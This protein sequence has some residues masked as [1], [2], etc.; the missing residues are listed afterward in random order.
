[1][2]SAIRSQL[3]SGQVETARSAL[4]SMKAF[5]NDANYVSRMH[6]LGSEFTK[7]KDY[8]TALQIYADLKQQYPGHDRAPGLQRSVIQTYLERG[9]QDAVGREL[10]VFFAEFAEHPKFV[11]QAQQLAADFA[12]RK[13]ADWAIEVYAGL[14][15]THPEHDRA[16]RFHAGLT[17]AVI[18]KGSLDE[19]DILV[20]LLER[21]YQSRPDYAGVVNDLGETYRTQKEYARAINVF[22]KTLAAESSQ[23][24][25]LSAYAGIARSAVWLDDYAIDPNSFEVYETDPNSPSANEMVIDSI[26]Q[27]LMAHYEQTRRQDYLVCEIGEDYYFKGLNAKSIGDVPQL[28]AEMNRAIEVWEKNITPYADAGYQYHVNSFIGNAYR[29]MGYY[30]TAIR[31][32]RQVMKD[33]PQ[34]DG[35]WFVQYKIILCYERSYN[36]GKIEQEDAQVQIIEACRELLERYPECS[37][38]GN[39]QRILLTY[40]AM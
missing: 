36:A 32:F 14:L 1:M 25:A 33:W 30:E 21:D 18:Q 9:D 10:G 5:E 38:K 3:A 7:Q 35:N 39:V 28:R 31:Y 20:D 8:S 37:V 40:E 27:K 4:V 17:K 2:D 15:E 19:A 29:D 24:D 11:E 26:I 22:R 6:E 12:G 16:I 34:S 23:Q 13:E